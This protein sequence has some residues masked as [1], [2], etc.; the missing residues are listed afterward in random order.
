MVEA[1]GIEPGRTR[2]A[3]MCT[4]SAQLMQILRRPKQNQ[5]FMLMHLAALSARVM[6]FRRKQIALSS[7]KTM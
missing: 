2:Q 4:S 1:V 5:R 3:M 7:T 6:H